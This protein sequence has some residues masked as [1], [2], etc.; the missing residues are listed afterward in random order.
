MKNWWIKFG[1]LLTG[2]NYNIL[3]SCTE[4]SYKQLKKYTSAILILIIL[5]AFVGYSFADRYIQ[6][7]MWGSIAIAVIFVLIII[8]IE[9]QIILNVGYNKFASI[10]RMVIAVIM[11]VLGSTILDQII[12]KD[13][14]EKKM[15]EIVDRQVKDQLPA[16]LSVINGKLAELQVEI[17]SLDHRNI[18]LYQQISKNPTINTVSTSVT[19]VPI[20]N[21]DGSITNKNQR[22]VSNT[23]IANPKIK[24][25][26][27]NNNN[28]IQLRKQHEEYSQRKL[29]AEESLR[30]ELKSKK[31]FLEELNAMLEILKES[32]V[33]LIF[34]VI[35]LA[36]LIS[37][38]LFV[39][40][41]KSDKNRSDYDL[42]MEHQLD[43]KRK[44]LEGLK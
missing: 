31:G 5:W 38:E 32:T 36:F 16:R 29:K 2:W 40:L 26:D 13:D 3:Q 10:F 30:A 17:D 6:T 4:A 14:I 12:F 35:L 34:Y 20:R 27:L 18:D 39:L 1:C 7:G 23:P 8:Q 25:A 11:A 43:Q 9:R 33:A 41:S 37:L 22:T 15:I 19:S 28:L 44:T 24:E 42:V 21:D